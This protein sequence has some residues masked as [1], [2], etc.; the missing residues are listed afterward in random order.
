[1]LQNCANNQKSHV[2]GNSNNWINNCFK[3]SCRRKFRQSAPEY[4]LL[5]KKPPDIK[6][7][8][9]TPRLS[10]K[11]TL[12]VIA[13]RIALTL[14]V[15]IVWFRCQVAVCVNK[16]HECAFFWC[17][18]YQKFNFDWLPLKLLTSSPKTENI[19]SF[20]CLLW[21]QLSVRIDGT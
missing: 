16:W 10:S 19:F 9:T 18:R 8:L 3:N 1:M 20:V 4:S 17:S 14:D 11:R 12:L 2:R 6:K 21:T 5:L 13:F 7:N 15:K